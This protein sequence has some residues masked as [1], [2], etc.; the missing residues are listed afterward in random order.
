M[1]STHRYRPVAYFAL[2]YAATW[3]PWLIGAY[4]ARR[5]GGEVYG[6]V[7]NLIGLVLGPTGVALWFV[8]GSGS[9]ALRRDFVD[10]IVN[11]R[12][13]RPPFALAA[14][15]LPFALILTAIWISTWFGEPADQF[16]LAGG[17]GLVPLVVIAM[18][19]AP[20]IEETGWHGYG[21]DSL[22][23]HHGMLE[24][25]ALFAV[26]WCLWHL[27]LVLVP[28][29][30]QH[31]VATLENPIFVLNFF[32]SILPAAFVA[33]WLYYRN[34][35]S[36]VGAV[37]VHSMLNGAA[38]L[39]NAGQVAKCIATLLYLAVAVLIVVFDREFR[40]GP[41]NFLAASP[42]NQRKAD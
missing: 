20:I 4:L 33:N 31:Y 10:R 37:L 17:S 27:P 32:V 38:V 23:A 40:A 12:R 2:V 29:T 5:P 7:F 21:V 11:L 26:L 14:V 28:G 25:T 1:E 9:P 3:I 16:A 22:R 13:I 35:R 18:L 19:L 39:V 34:D 24:A 6:F 36:I 15:I 8:F 42:A 41:R 30:Y